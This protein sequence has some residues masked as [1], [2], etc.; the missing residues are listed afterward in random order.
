MV[1][2]CRRG[3]EAIQV[4]PRL[5]ESTLSVAP[6][7]QLGRFL[8]DVGNGGQRR[9][10]GDCGRLRKSRRQRGHLVQEGRT[11]SLLRSCPED[12][13]VSV[14]DGSGSITDQPRT[15][16]WCKRKEVLPAA[17]A[18]AMREP[19]TRAPLSEDKKRWL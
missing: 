7:Q 8:K 13:W 16:A 3:K 9:G 14:E 15:S 11:R 18:P 1:L 12:T 4:W 2:A 10:G 17:V 6:D 19:K 5:K